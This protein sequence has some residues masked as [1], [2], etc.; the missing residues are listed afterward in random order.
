MVCLV[1]KE[2]Q[3]IKLLNKDGDNNNDDQDE[4]TAR[5]GEQGDEERY[6]YGG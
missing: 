4:D 2:E 1:E 3:K 5:Y 6:Q